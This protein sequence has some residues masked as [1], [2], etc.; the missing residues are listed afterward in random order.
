MCRI[1]AADDHW[2]ISLISWFLRKIFYHMVY[3]SARSVESGILASGF[4]LQTFLQ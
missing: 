3:K 4:S 2:L 1:N